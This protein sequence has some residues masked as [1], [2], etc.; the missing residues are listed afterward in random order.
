MDE[1]N[2]RFLLRFF[3]GIVKKKRIERRMLG[4][5]SEVAMRSAALAFVRQ[6][7]SQFEVGWN[8]RGNLEGRAS[9][10][11]GKRRPGKAGIRVGTE[12]A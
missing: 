4:G 12:L 7:I 8:K 10:R 9:V 6:T 1:R 2:A 5:A 11:T 3:C